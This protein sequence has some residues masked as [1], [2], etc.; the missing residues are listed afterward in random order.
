MQNQNAI[1]STA[2]IDPTEGPLHFKANQKE[3]KSTLF[4]DKAETFNL[5]LPLLL[6]PF[7][8]YGTLSGWG[9]TIQSRMVVQLTAAIF[10]ISTVHLGF[11]L[12]NMTCLPEFRSLINTWGKGQP[13]RIWVKWSLVYFTLVSIGLIVNGLVVDSIPGDITRLSFYYLGLY[14]FFS[15]FHTL[16][17]TLG[18]LRLYNFNLQSF[19]TTLGATKERTWSPALERGCIYAMILIC[20]VQSFLFMAYPSMKA[21]DAVIYGSTLSAAL[22][23]AVLFLNTYRQQGASHS[24]KA[25]YMT[26]LLYYIPT[27]FV[28]LCTLAT[29]IIHGIEYLLITRKLRQ[30][31]KGASKKAW[32]A[33]AFLACGF[34]C[35]TWFLSAHQPFV[36]YL[37]GNEMSQSSLFLAFS[38][39]NVANALFHFFLDS[40]LFRFKDPAVR[41]HIGGLLAESK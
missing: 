7:V 35:M 12:A 4:S 22:V 11:T 10:L 34:I 2:T 17:Q 37:M 14:L 26:R 6:L 32:W 5:L 13:W 29:E 39:I 21:S 38:S 1:R 20:G 3:S 23:V 36:R 24:T 28:F 30:N 31:S 15:R 8:V 9:T 16:M 41:N 19:Q 27:P 18:F 33:V 40:L 25:V